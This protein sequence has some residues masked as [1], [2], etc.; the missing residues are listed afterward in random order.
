MSRKLSG[1]PAASYTYSSD[2][3]TVTVT[4]AGVAAST[5][6]DQF[7][8]TITQHAADGTST[9]M[10]YDSAGRLASQQ[11]VSTAGAAQTAATWEYDSLGR[12]TKAKHPGGA[13]A[14]QTFAY[15]LNPQNA[16]WSRMIACLDP[17]GVNATT[18]RDQNALGQPTWTQGPVQAT[19]SMTYDG[20]GNLA[21]VTVTDASTNAAQTRTFVYD[22]LSR[23]ISKTEP[24]TGTTQ[25]GNFDALKHPTTVTETGGRVRTLTF[26]GLGRRVGLANGND[27]QV[28]SYSGLNLTSN[29][30]QSSTMGTVTQSYAYG[31]PAGSLSEEDTNQPGLPVSAIKYT[32]DGLARLNAIQYPS[33]RTIGYGYDAVNRIANV[34]NNG[35][36]LVTAISYNDLGQRQRVTFASGA[37]SDW[38]SKD[39]GTHLGQWTIGY[40]A[41]GA[42][43]DYTAN[44]R[45]FRYDTAERLTQAGEW[46]MAPDAKG[47]VLSANA[48]DLGL[49][50]C[51][52]GHDG[53]DNNT[54]ANATG[55][56][57]GALINF[58]INPALNNLTPPTDTGGAVT[59]WTY[60]NA[61]NG[62]AKTVGMGLGSGS[63]QVTPA[64]DGIGRLVAVSNGQSGAV[65][66]SRYSGSGLR[67]ARFNSQDATQNRY[68]AYALSGVLLTEWNQALAARDVVYLGATP[69]A[70]IDGAGVHELHVDHLGTPRLITAGATGQL[71]G[72]QS[73]SAFG[74]YLGS[75]S[76]GYLPV[77]GYT[78][79]LQADKSG[80]IYMKGRFY[81]PGW[82]RFLNSDQGVDPN[83]LN[84]I[85]Y[86][87]GSPM[88]R[89]DPSGLMLVDG[90]FVPFGFCGEPQS[91]FDRLPINQKLDSPMTKQQWESMPT[92][93]EWSGLSSIGSGQVGFV[94]VE[95]LPVPR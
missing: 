84:Q 39:G 45:I 91:S 32:Y 51:T 42:Q 52:Y 61:S 88:M 12:V 80:L 2:F 40:A 77:T 66:T 63:P 59:G 11:A 89:T 70:E 5:V 79:H 92:L 64:W 56:G 43:T 76:G 74:E 58:A 81:S 68:Y 19:S 86:A 54:Y 1:V 65:E 72:R 37:Y 48:P 57:S 17:S 20:L 73:F 22:E 85:A 6:Q 36:N 33:G 10:G 90:L 35:A 30:S 46:T 14:T 27:G 75:V 18:T 3:A 8:R 13:G 25:F 47:R 55:A 4:Q 7:H 60:A 83:Q 26:D 29:T 69:L 82:H 94:G 95:L 44:P 9:T 50:A 67:V 53:F 71:E 23:L 87:G 21:T 34:Q 15:A 16:A 41:G 78:G 93:G 62:E 38:A 28:W 24:E 49:G 31:G